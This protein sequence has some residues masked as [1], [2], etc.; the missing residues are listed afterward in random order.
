MAAGAAGRGAGGRKLAG[1]TFDS[2]EERVG[3]ARFRAILRAELR[4]HAEGF[5]AA[6]MGS[7]P[8]VGFEHSAVAALKL[9]LIRSESAAAVA[10][11]AAAAKEEAEAK[12]ELVGA[13][14]SGA[15]SATGLLCLTPP[16][17]ERG[18]GNTSASLRADAK[19]HATS[20]TYTIGCWLGRHN[21]FSHCQP[22]VDSTNRCYTV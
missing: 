9:L 7:T 11:A 19:V 15:P 10:V 14:A 18:G 1:R 8:L 4:A 22:E 20:S 12:E 5:L 16:N 2:A 21:R 6:A 17:A 3:P 13:G